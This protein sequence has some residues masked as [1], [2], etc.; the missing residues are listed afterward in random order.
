M[1]SDGRVPEKILGMT[2][3]GSVVELD[4]A[5]NGTWIK[6]ITVRDGNTNGI[7]FTINDTIVITNIHQPLETI[8]LSGSILTNNPGFIDALNTGEEYILI[9]SHSNTSMIESSNA[10]TNSLTGG[11]YFDDAITN[12]IQIRSGLDLGNVQGI[13]IGVTCTK[14]INTDSLGLINP[15]LKLIVEIDRTTVQIVFKEGD[16]LIIKNNYQTI[17]KTLTDSDVSL[18]N[19]TISNV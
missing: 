1:T 9:D 7:N 11:I 19:G 16:V 4:V 17:S 3:Y 2:Q 12:D 6:S 5:N 18:L 10:L 14:A 8:E 15:I 13:T